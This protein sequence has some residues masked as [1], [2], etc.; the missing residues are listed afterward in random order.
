MITSPLG[1]R[2]VPHVAAPADAALI[3]A[4]AWQGVMPEVSNLP[5]ILFPG[6][7]SGDLQ[8]DEWQFAD[9]MRGEETLCVG[10][11]NTIEP[12]PPY[13]VLNLGSHWK[14]IEIDEQGSIARSR[15][16]LSG[17]LIYATQTATIL[18]SALPADKLQTLDE[19][20]FVK[21]MQE[22]SRSGL[23]RALFCVRLLELQQRT[24]PAERMSFLL[25]VY[26]AA[27]LA[28]LRAAGFLSPS[29]QVV[30]T[31][32][33]AIASAWLLALAQAGIGRELIQAEALERAYLSGIRSLLFWWGLGR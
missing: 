23:A 13:T 21:G 1:L 10:L 7:K 31:G 2:E 30:L 33:G 3:A 32:T 15:T 9:V 4:N 27:D 16:T 6:V 20:W 22:A 11:Q 28:A 18:A 8:S 25:G 29:R 12:Q 17:E 19:S 5:L 24:S 14:A 26:V